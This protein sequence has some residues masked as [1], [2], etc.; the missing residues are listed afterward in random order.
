MSCIIDAKEG[1]YVDVTD[2]PGAFLH[3]DMNKDV[4]MLLEATKAELILKLEPRLY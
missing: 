2:I 3:E 1:K 4:Q